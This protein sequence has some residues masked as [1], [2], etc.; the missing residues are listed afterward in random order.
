M[1]VEEAVETRPPE[2]LMKKRVEVPA[3]KVCWTWKALP[4]CPVRSISVRLIEFVEVAPMVA[5]ELIAEVVVPNP[6]CVFVSS[7]ESRDAEETAV[8]PV[9]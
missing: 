4:V 3:P 2:E 9:Q 1:K 5:M 8:E 6:N 7:I